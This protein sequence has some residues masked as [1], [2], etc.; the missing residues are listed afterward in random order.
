MSGLPTSNQNQSGCTPTAS[1]CV[2][3][4]G[5]DLP[6]I[7]LCTGDSISDV[8][9][10]L[11]Q[12][13]CNIQDQLQLSNFSTALLC[14]DPIC[15]PLTDFEDL[16]NFIINKLCA[17]QAQIQANSIGSGGGCPDPTTGCPIPVPSCFQTTNS[18]G[19]QVTT[20]PMIPYIQALGAQICTMLTNNASLTTTVNQHTVQIQA[21]QSTPPPAPTP[22]PT[23]NLP[24][25][26]G[27]STGATLVNAID[28]VASTLCTLQNATD[29][30]T[31]ILSA[32]NASCIN[33]NSPALG[34]PGSTLMSNPSWDSSNTLAASVNNLWLTVCDL[35]SA[36]TAL[37][38][39]CGGGCDS[40]VL[41]MAASY[42]S[43]I[44]TLNFSSTGAGSFN[45]CVAG[46]TIIITDR[47]GNTQTVV[48]V[49]P[50]QLASQNQPFNITLN[51]YINTASQ[52]DITL[53]GCWM[54]SVKGLTCE[55]Q[56]VQTLN[57]TPAC[58]TLTLS[59][60][61][62]GVTYSFVNAVAPPCT[63]NIQI[64]QAGTVIA[65]NT[66]TNPALSATVTGSFT[67]LN[68]NTVYQVQVQVNPYNLTP[69]PAYCPAVQITTQVLVENRWLVSGTPGSGGY[70]IQPN[71]SRWLINGT[72]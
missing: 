1:N 71:G 58:P 62:T 53:N 2:I 45:D 39:C 46:S 13:L 15:P 24:S 49:S 66:V 61:T 69:A 60:T 23:V 3:W 16:V 33:Q 19:D 11:A 17:L 52:L 40:V 28:A 56:I 32:V 34:T 25:C 30:P 41:N 72:I 21:L 68:P 22:L 9:A 50:L 12:I 67:G 44:I 6:C 10:K 51:S 59:S 70:F 43:G 57:L 48:G 5:P 54:N 14:F 36:V 4:Q 65:T 42:N 47:S 55:R 18:L 26:V 37:A 29:T 8:T 64:L 63:Y 35:R 7:N 27:G 20:L 31:N 38:N